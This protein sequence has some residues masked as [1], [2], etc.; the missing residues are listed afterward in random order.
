MVALLGAF[1]ANE[2]AFGKVFDADYGIAVAHAVVE[3]RGSRSEVKWGI[4]KRRGGDEED[5]GTA[6]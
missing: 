4:V 3:G 2:V 5:L 6:I 1:V